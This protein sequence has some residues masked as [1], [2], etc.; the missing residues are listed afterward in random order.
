MWT[1]EQCLSLLCWRHQAEDKFIGSFDNQKRCWEELAVRLNE[2]FLADFSAD[3]VSFV[4]NRCN[5]LYELNLEC[6]KSK[7]VDAVQWKYF[8]VMDEIRGG[9]K[10]ISEI[11]IP[12]PGNHLLTEFN[13]IRLQYAY[14]LADDMLCDTNSIR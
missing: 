4:W 6:L 8:A 14:S 7:G 11:C 10:E 9:T 2:K 12:K 3:E 13:S 5:L 1:T